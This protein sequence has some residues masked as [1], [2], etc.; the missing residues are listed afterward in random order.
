M[1]HFS[2]RARRMKGRFTG[3][4]LFQASHQPVVLSTNVIEFSP[5]LTLSKP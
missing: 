4:R 1:G 2:T 3:R 5:T